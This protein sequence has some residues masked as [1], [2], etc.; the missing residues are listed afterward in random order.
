MN[1]LLEYKRIKQAVLNKCSVNLKKEIRK[2]ENL[3]T[4][5]GENVYIPPNR[6]TQINFRRN[7]PNASCQIKRN[8]CDNHVATLSK[9]SW[10]K[11]INEHGSDDNEGNVKSCEAVQSGHVDI[12]HV[13]EDD[14]VG[15]QANS[16]R[17]C[18]DVQRHESSILCYLKFYQKNTM[19]VEK[20]KYCY[21]CERAKP[22][23][24]NEQHYQ[25]EEDTSIWNNKKIKSNVNSNLRDISSIMEEIRS[26][27]K[28]QEDA[29]NK[30]QK[31]TT[32]KGDHTKKKSDK[33]DAGKNLSSYEKFYL[34][35]V[36]VI[37]GK[38]ANLRNGSYGKEEELDLGLDVNNKIA[39]NYDI[40]EHM[41][42]RLA[43]LKN[44]EKRHLQMLLDLFDEYKDMEE[45]ILRAFPRQ[46]LKKGILKVYKFHETNTLLAKCIKT[47]ND[48][49]R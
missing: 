17:I 33:K 49:S 20:Y 10:H 44:I 7:I 41:E 45:R 34:S 22:C 23:S 9:L 14:A 5:K 25:Y 36:K 11:K 40:G 8:K 48:L 39:L 16:L 32:K 24:C 30:A 13:Y 31:F 1:P 47:S 3:K 19:G 42:K 43:S 2:N 6:D 28:R 38:L 27:K 35:K 12:L 4:E 46:S 18:V 15:Q 29:P 26:N 21:I 37:K